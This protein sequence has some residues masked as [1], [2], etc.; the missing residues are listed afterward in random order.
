MARS[1]APPPLELDAEQVA[2]LLAR[3]HGSVS[4]QDYRLLQAIISTLVTVAELLAKKKASIRRLTKLLFGVRTEKASA[5]LPG[6]P[7]Q[8]KDE[9]SPPSAALTAGNCRGHGRNGAED[10]PG[11]ARIGVSHPDLKPG[12]AC[13]EGCSGRLY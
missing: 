7:S 6:S 2:G 3:L 10:Y 4:E 12:D 5:L 13:P 9:A 11:A 1:P 8:A